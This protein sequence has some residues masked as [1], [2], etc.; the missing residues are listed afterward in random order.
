MKYL[1]LL[2]FLTFSIIACKQEVKPEI[3]ASSDVD[4]TP[5]TVAEAPKR[6]LSLNGEF[7]FDGKNAVMQMGNNMFAVEMS[8][9]TKELIKQCEQFKENKYDFVRVAV[10]GYLVDNP[11]E[12]WER[13]VLVKTILRVQKSTADKNIT[14]KSS[15]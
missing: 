3:D 13:Q 4:T 11:N 12:G 10:N 5:Q 14:I 9:K 1:I 15:K 7:L 6:L 8:D 2:F